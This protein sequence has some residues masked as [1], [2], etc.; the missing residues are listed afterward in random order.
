MPP[1]K[2]YDA[3]L[4]RAFTLENLLPVLFFTLLC[5]LWIKSSKAYTKVVQIRQALIFSLVLAG[6][7]IILMIF[8]FTQ[9]N[10]SL[11]ED[12]PFHLCNFLTLVYP[13]TLIYQSR[14]FF[15]ILY[16]WVLVGTFQAILTP[17]LKES[18][19]HPIY[20]KYWLVH[21]GLVMLVIHGIFVLNW[22]VY[23]KDLFNAIIG[24]NVYLVFSFIVNITFGSNYFYSMHKPKTASLLDYL[25]PWPWYLISGQLIMVFLFYL[26]F[27]PIH[28]KAKK[29]NL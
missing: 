5:I 20:F 6:T 29:T 17:E 15:G 19:P 18:F 2:L 23:K 26:Y 12:L 21:C 25:G 7:N 10:L 16:F 28:L 4:F 11:T 9:N 22:T 8:K 27:L 3:D 13:V 14:W 24:A 1:A